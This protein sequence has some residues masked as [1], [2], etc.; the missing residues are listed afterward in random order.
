MARRSKTSLTGCLNVDKSD[1]VLLAKV[2]ALAIAFAL[3][4]CYIAAVLGLSMR[5][6]L[7]VLG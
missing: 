7:A 6:F 3:A 5:L 2:V 4:A 1:A